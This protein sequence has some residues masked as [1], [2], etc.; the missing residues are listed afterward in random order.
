MIEGKLR[1][2][3]RDLANIQVVVIGTGL[4]LC[5]EDREFLS[6]TEPPSMEI[7]NGQEGDRGSSDGRSEESSGEQEIEQLRTELQKAKTEIRM[8]NETISS[9]QTQVGQDKDRIR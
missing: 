8:L 7:P 3:E 9:L 5:G 1:E 6:I 4:S 2:M